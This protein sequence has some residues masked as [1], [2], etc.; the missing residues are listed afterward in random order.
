MAKDRPKKQIEYFRKN[1]EPFAW[2]LE[3]LNAE[4]QTAPY[5]RNDKPNSDMVAYYVKNKW[6]ANQ[7]D[8][9]ALNLVFATLD[10][11]NDSQH[12]YVR[13][14]TLN[15]IY[16]TKLDSKKLRILAD[17][18]IKQTKDI[19]LNIYNSNI[20]DTI[21]KFFKEKY[22]YDPYSFVS[23]YF[24]HINENAYPIYDSYVKE[25]LLW[26]RYR[27]VDFNFV[28]SDLENYD[29]FKTIIGD[30]INTFNLN[31]SL[32]E[33]DKFLWTAGKEF[34]PQYVYED[35]IERYK[36]VN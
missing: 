27:F 23:K 18:L 10:D 7:F 11:T 25:M 14:L 35:L 24:S 31:C 8:E 17:V 32:R 28:V 4:Y 5:S 22:D 9:D 15:S 2:K 20:V 21:R 13:L 3:L 1:G 19:D 34:F 33:A 36:I 16:S 12:M 29:R 30:F 6:S 26:Y